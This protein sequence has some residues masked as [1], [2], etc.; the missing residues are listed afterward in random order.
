M[1]D[2]TLTIINKPMAK[3]IFFNRR[4]IIVGIDKV[5]FYKEIQLNSILPNANSR[6]QNFNAMVNAI[7]DMAK[8]EYPYDNLKYADIIYGVLK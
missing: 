7:F 1:Q 3:N 4:P 2:K 6:T 5:N 8:Q